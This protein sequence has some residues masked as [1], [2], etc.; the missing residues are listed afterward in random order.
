MVQVREVW[1]WNANWTSGGRCA[2]SRLNSYTVASSRSIETPYGLSKPETTNNCVGGLTTAPM[3][4]NQLWYV[5]R[6][7]V[8]VEH[9]SHTVQRMS[10]YFGITGMLKT[11]IHLLTFR[12]RKTSKDK[13][14]LLLIV[15]SDEIAV[16]YV[17]E[18]R[19]SPE[20]NLSRT[21]PANSLS[22]SESSI[23]SDIWRMGKCHI[24]TH[25]TQFFVTSLYSEYDISYVNATRRQDISELAEIWKGPNSI[26]KDLQEG[27]TIRTAIVTKER[28]EPAGSELVSVRVQAGA[29]SVVP[30]WKYNCWG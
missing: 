4:N 25:R 24:S 23:M 8:N 13:S 3:T 29:K 15:K 12:I 9:E 27:P 28:C 16:S 17:Y 18:V 21:E 11:K 19:F 7:A 5:F 30:A 22:G 26:N 2:V 1:S 6:H 20:P 10:S 14:V